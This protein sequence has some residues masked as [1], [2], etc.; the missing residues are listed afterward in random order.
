MQF[1]EGVAGTQTPKYVAKDQGEAHWWFGSLATIKAAAIDTGGLLS[2]IE[3]QEAP[4]AE[5]P[6]HVHHEEDESFWL[7]EGDV[8]FEV[9]DTIIEAHAGDFVFGPR[10]IPHRYIVGPNGCR[11]LFIM[12]PGGF[13]NMIVEMSTPA[14]SLTLPPPSDEEPDWERIAAIARAH[15]NELLG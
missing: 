5:A 6:L 2:V 3:V 13:E 9:G 8:T 10:D 14:P 12:T 4:G 7:L 11:M 15:G 1:Q